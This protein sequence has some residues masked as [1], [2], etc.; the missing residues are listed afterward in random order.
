MLANVGTVNLISGTF[1][2]NDGGGMRLLGSGTLTLVNTIV[3]NSLSGSDCSGAV[4]SLG[5]NLDSDNAWNL[6][7]P[8]DLPG[9]DPLL[10]PLPDNGGPTETHALLPGSPAIDAGDDS[11]A[12]DTDQRGAPRP[13]GPA[14]DIGAFE[15]GAAPPPVPSLAHWGLIAMAGLLAFLVLWWVWRAPI[16]RRA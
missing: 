8:D 14:S 6:T 7:D 16:H 5:H 15:L 3:A 10:G 11:A 4:T 1:H 2:H 13:Y 9:E 12:P